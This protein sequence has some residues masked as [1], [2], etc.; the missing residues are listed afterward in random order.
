MRFAVNI[1]ADDIAVANSPE[2][3]GESKVKLSYQEVG[4]IGQITQAAPAS[5]TYAA[6]TPIFA[7][8]VAGV[9]LAL[10]CDTGVRSSANVVVDLNV[11][12]ADATTGTARATFAVP[13]FA[14]DQSANLPL[15][16]A[17][18]IIWAQVTTPAQYVANNVVVNSSPL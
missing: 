3:G 1:P 4:I 18:D 5:G 17:V 13:T 8:P 16:L 7:F 15:G 9:D 14:L 11:T 2:I 12:F 10:I 6:Q